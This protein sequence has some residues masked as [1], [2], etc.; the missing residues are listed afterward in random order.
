MSRNSGGG[1]SSSGKPSILSKIK[2]SPP[3]AWIVLGIMLWVHVNDSDRGLIE[4]REKA[5]E[6]MRYKQY[7]PK[8]VIT[9]KSYD[10]TDYQAKRQQR[11]IDNISRTS[12]SD[13]YQSWL[14]REKRREKYLKQQSLRLTKYSEKYGH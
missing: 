6:A 8:P 12:R 4:R 13:T 11:A 10:Y 9:P 2:I 5:A 7:A 14:K 1:N 3:V